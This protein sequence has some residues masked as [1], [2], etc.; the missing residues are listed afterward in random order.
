MDDLTITSATAGYSVAKRSLADRVWSWLGFRHARVE[1]PDEPT[2]GFV[3]GAVITKTVVWFSWGDRLRV[4]LGGRVEVE[5]AMETDVV[6][7]RT[8]SVSGVGVL[9]PT[10]PIL[11]PAS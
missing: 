6:V 5:T 3:E 2:E 11:R 8:R 4:L 9:P 10:Y 7:R 1:R